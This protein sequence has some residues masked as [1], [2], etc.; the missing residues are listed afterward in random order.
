[1][2]QIN[3]LPGHE[4]GAAA[5]TGLRAAAAAVRARVAAVAADKYLLGGAGAAVAAAAAVAWLHA[6]QSAQAAEAGAREAAAVADSTRYAALLAARRSAVAER[7]SVRRQ[8][9]VIAEIDS[10]RYAWAHVMDEVS[11]SLPP[12]TWLTAVQQT[13]APPTPDGTADTLAVAP[14]AAPGAAAPGAARADSAGR[15]SAGAAAPR[16]VLAFRVVGQTVDIQALTAFMRDLETSP[17]VQRVQLARSEPTQVDGR[18]VTEF[19][20]DAQYERPPRSLL[21]AE[22]L[23][24]AVAP[25]R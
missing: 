20:L 24:V 14:A 16:A 2:I 22:R 17:F 4:S 7:D 11:R 15:D 3:L 13:S 5:P 6:A 19:T 10:T 25:A 21:R 8:L 23:A 18:E 9:A 12:Y 1:M